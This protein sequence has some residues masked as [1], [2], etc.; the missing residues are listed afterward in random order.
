[1]KHLDLFSGIGGFA[2]AV[3]TVWPGSTHTFCEIDPFCQKILSKHWPQSEIYHDIRQL[4]IT[5]KFDLLTGGFPCQPFSA[6]G[7]KRGEDDDRFLWPEMLRVIRQSRPA[8]IIGENVAG[9][10]EMALEQTCIDLEGEGYEVQPFIIPACAVDA[11]HRRDRV[12]IIAHDES[13][14]GEEG[15]IFSAINTE[16][17]SETPKKWNDFWIQSIGSNTFEFRKEDEPFI[18]GMDDGIPNRV[19]RIKALGN[20]IVPQVA[21]EIM[22]AINYKYPLTTK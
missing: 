20:A 6:A 5:E 18:C 14:R 21:I 8:W 4:N 11:I 3:D 16:C 7:K 9:I 19:D 17:S 15:S 22:R 13:Q 1:M 2:L 12:W 10:V